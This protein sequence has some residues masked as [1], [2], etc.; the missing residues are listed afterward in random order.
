MFNTKLDNFPLEFLQ[1]M[2]LVQHSD[3]IK[4][5]QECSDVQV[6]NNGTIFSSK[7]T[8]DFI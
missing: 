8:L 2:P 3:F 6:V 1:I 5:Q 7:I 4:V